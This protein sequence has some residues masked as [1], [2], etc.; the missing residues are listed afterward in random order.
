MKWSCLGFIQR[1]E[2]LCSNV[3]LP[4]VGVPSCRWGLWAALLQVGSRTP[5]A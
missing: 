3:A 4:G 2:D 1:S 5:P